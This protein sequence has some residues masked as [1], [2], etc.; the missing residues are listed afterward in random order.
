[1]KKKESEVNWKKKGRKTWSVVKKDFCNISCIY[2]Q[3]DNDNISLP[4]S[5]NEIFSWS[6]TIFNTK[7]CAF[8]EKERFNNPSHRKFLLG[9]RYCNL[10]IFSI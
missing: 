10:T 1:M 6:K 2:L 5:F 7:V 9:S 4:F 8:S 3:L